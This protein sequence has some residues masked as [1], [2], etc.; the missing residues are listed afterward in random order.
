[1][2]FTVRRYTC[3]KE[4]SEAAAVPGCS[5]ARLQEARGRGDPPGPGD[6]G[7][8]VC[9]APDHNAE[10]EGWDSFSCSDVYEIAENFAINRS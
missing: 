5:H 7:P 9:V 10:R 4:L 1:M 6:P 2:L 3:D 8:G